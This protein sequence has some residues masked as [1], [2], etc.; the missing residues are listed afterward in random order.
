MWTSSP[1]LP[2]GL[3]KLVSGAYAPEVKYWASAGVCARHC[4]ALDM[5]HVFPKLLSPTRPAG[6]GFVPVLIL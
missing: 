5:K 1:W 6:R 2:S 4:T 3:V